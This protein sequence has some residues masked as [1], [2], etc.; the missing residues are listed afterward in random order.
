MRGW[1]VL[2]GMTALLCSGPLYSC[3][4]AST[5]GSGG[6]FPEIPL[7]ASPGLPAID[8]RRLGDDARW[9][10]APTFTTYLLPGGG[11]SRYLDQAFGVGGEL[12]ARPGGGPGPGKSGGEEGTLRVLLDFS[13][14]Q[15]TPGATLDPA[16]SGTNAFTGSSSSGGPIPPVPG[17]A[18]ITGF[19]LRGG[20]AR[21]LPWMTPA[22][23]G[24][25]R[26][27]VPY[28][29]AD[30]GLADLAVS[31]VPGLSGHPAGP[32]ADLGAG[33]SLRLPGSR[34]G[35]FGEVDP[36]VIDLSGNMMTIMPLVAGIMVRF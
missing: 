36:T 28:L 1:T 16:V 19:V 18:S 23:W 12:S 4:A 7:P 34:L 3:G 32:M 5:G 30:F 15:M 22:P 35:V 21:D 29:R 24:L 6:G 27:I 31:G 20:L 8:A 9:S 10:I 14:F 2:L 33:L 13:L 11:L 25:R 17:S 26:I